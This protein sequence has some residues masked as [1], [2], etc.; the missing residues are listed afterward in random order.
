MVRAL[1]LVLPVFNEADNLEPCIRQAR[2]ALDAAAR[3]GVA[4]AWEIVAVDD[5]SQDDSWERLAALHASEPRLRPV[6]HPRNLGYGAALRTGFREARHDLVLFTDADL[7]F[8]LSE[9]PRLLALAASADVVAGFRAP[10]RDPAHRRLNAWAWGRLVGQLFDLPLRDV[11][12]AF[13]LFDR[14]VLDAVELRSEGALVNTELLVRAR[15]AGFSLAEVPVSHHP[16]VA[17]RASG[18]RPRV[19][20]RAF[21]E[22][23]ALQREL[24]GLAASPPR[25]S[26]AAPVG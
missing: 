2:A 21:R 11:N 23:L 10:R 26:A 17:G 13:K 16:R 25:V 9:L 19:V 14:R 5:G 8:D 12:C 6:R 4:G 24:R 20:L 7:Q 15:A 22:L 18:A 1:S 3:Q